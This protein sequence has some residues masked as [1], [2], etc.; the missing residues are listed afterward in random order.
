MFCGCNNIGADNSTGTQPSATID[1]SATQE[2]AYNDSLTGKSIENAGDGNVE[3]EYPAEELTVVVKTKDELIA[4]LKSS[5]G[6]ESNNE[7][8]KQ[9]KLQDLEYYYE[10]AVTFPGY[11]LMYIEV[12]EYRIFYYYMPE[13]LMKDDPVMFDSA[14]GIVVTIARWEGESED[15]LQPIVEQTG[16]EPNKDNV[17]FD[18]KHNSLTWPVGQTWADIRFP[19]SFTQYEEMLSFCKVN[20]VMIDN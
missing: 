7:V 8:Y 11:E 17:V 10:P 1:D 14:N 20:K 9:N 16:I 2:E 5:R 13:S 3:V 18:K 15:P 19:R 12:T 4:T 6:S